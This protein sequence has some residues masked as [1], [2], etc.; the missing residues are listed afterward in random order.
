MIYVKLN[1][2]NTI[3][4]I[5][6][7]PFD[8]E[9]GLNKT[10]SELIANGEGLLVEELPIAQSCPDKIATLK[11]N[12]TELYYDYVDDKN[13][14]SEIE[15]LQNEIDSLKA[16]KEELTIATLDLADT[17]GLQDIQLQEQEEALIDLANTLAEVM[18]NG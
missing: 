17:V 10:A 12:G 15:Q 2:D 14:V 16:G 1:D 3:S 7:V 6:Y 9:Y 4:F 18:N 5:H 8:E 13:P 11:Y